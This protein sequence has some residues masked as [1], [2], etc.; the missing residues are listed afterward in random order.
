EGTDSDPLGRLEG[1]HPIGEPSGEIDEQLGH[2]QIDHVARS[3]A[4]R[5]ELEPSAHG[6]EV[7]ALHDQG[8]LVPNAQRGSCTVEPETLEGGFAF[9][10]EPP[11]EALGAKGA[12]A[13]HPAGLEEDVGAGVEEGLAEGGQLK[14]ATTDLGVSPK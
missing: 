9:A 13:H 4:S 1:L 2:G 14:A 5:L 8:Q 3:A 10:F 7:L 11:V 6:A 12:E